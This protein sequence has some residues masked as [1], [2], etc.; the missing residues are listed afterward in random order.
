MK[1]KQ[2]RKRTDLIRVL[3]ALCFILIVARMYD[4]QIIS[5]QKYVDLAMS[6]QTMQ[7]TIFAK[8]GEIYM[9]DGDNTT[10]VVMN[11][12]VYTISV[13]PFLLRSEG[14][15][16][17]KEDEAKIDQLVQGYAVNTWDKVFANEASRYAVIAKNV[18]YERAKQIKE[19]KI[20][21][22]YAQGSTKRVYPEGDL[23]AQVLGFVNADGKGQYGIEGSLNKELTGVNGILKTVKDVNNIPLTIGKNN[24]RVP[25]QDGKNVVLSIDRN[26]QKKTED[27]IKATIEKFHV[28]NASAVVMNPRNGQILAMAGTPTYNPAEY[29]K[30][31]DARAFQTDV[32][33]SAF[34]PA[35]VCKT[36]ALAAAVDSGVMTPETTYNNTD[37]VTIDG[38][39]IQNAIKGHTGI[40]SMQEV[41]TYSLNT[42][43]I[44]A[45]RLLGGSE[46]E[47]TYQGKEKLYDYYYNRFGLG[48]Y[49]GIE[50]A[51][52][53]GTV[54]P[55]T[56]ID[57]T[58]ARYANMTFGQSL[59][60]TMIQVATA[61]SAVVNGGDY[62]TPT[63][64]AGEI[65]N[66]EFVRDVLKERDH[67]AIE[68]STSETMRKMLHTARLVF[69]NVKYYDEGVYVGGKT[70]TA[71]VVK[72]GKYTFDETIATY[73][74]YGARS[75]TDYPEYVIMTKV[76]EDNRRLDGGM[77][78][79]P[80]FDEIS[81][82]M[83]NYLKMR[84]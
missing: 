70:G 33:M 12:K 22:V 24:V 26:I 72:N 83:V 4:L 32:T 11:E 59:D 78:A 42:G 19:A 74:G 29:A 39:P 21:G 47:I 30:V 68:S 9:M 40:I 61:F 49:T 48:K 16:E 55:P 52:S 37:L 57:G 31:T 25:A 8:R 5:H 76:W 62:Y 65:K 44:Q 81:Q 23:A 6:Q 75:E 56:D 34:N 3:L 35:S 54:I 64:V 20:T 46:T 82:F 45:L 73:I 71:Q 14:G 69:P 13:D 53:K 41:L 66:G 51:E 77:H 28:T 36:F 79:K 60:L 84:R 1:V 38:W 10:P 50:L 17:L 80:I 7:N 18:P 27:A 58:N 15:K 43:S 67:Q 2:M 63:L